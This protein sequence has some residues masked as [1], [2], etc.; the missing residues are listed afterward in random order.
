[1]TDAASYISTTDRWTK[2]L[3]TESTTGTLNSIEEK[4]HSQKLFD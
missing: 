4:D 2:A 1:M 3:P